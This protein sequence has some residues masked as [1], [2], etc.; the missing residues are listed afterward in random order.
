MIGDELTICWHYSS[1]VQSEG[2]VE[3]LI[4]KSYLTGDDRALFERKINRSNIIVETSENEL[5]GWKHI[6]DRH[7]DRERFT[8]R[9][10]FPTNWDER[11]IMGALGAVIRHGTPSSYQ[12]LR[13]F[14]FRT[15]Y[16]NSGYRDYRVTINADGSVRTFHPLG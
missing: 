8:G 5:P 9:S 3:T 7:V 10:K 12:G 15:N 2:P 14:T 13:T 6:Y 1:C 4:T 16:N 11:D